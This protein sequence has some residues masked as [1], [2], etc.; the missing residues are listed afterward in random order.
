MT[1]TS[2]NNNLSYLKRGEVEKWLDRIEV[3]K[4]ITGPN[5]RENLIAASSSILP[6]QPITALT[7]GDT[8]FA[9]LSE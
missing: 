6:S 3:S 9:I 1:N 2:K 8:S 5:A 4:T 7:C